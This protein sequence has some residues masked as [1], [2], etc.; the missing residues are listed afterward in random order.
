MRMY[1][2][3]TER[4]NKSFTLMRDDLTLFN[5]TQNSTKSLNRLQ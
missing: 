2:R 4:P 5:A 3:I 1:N